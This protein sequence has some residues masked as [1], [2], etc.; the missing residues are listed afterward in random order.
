MIYLENVYGINYIKNLSA[1]G[2][3]SRRQAR[4]AAIG[5]TVGLASRGLI[6]ASGGGAAANI[7]WRPG[8]MALGWGANKAN[9][10]HTI[11]RRR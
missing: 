11:N 7:A 3:V 1:V 10:A 2:T 5:G 6:G 9:T 8:T 4:A